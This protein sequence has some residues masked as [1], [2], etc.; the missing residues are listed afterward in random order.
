MGRLGAWRRGRLVRKPSADRP[1]LPPPR[2]RPLTPAPDDAVGVQPRPQP[3]NCL[4]FSKLPSDLRL[5]ILNMAFGGRMLHI[6]L[7]FD[8]PLLPPPLDPPAPKDRHH[9]AIYT[10]TGKRTGEK[11]WQWRGAVCHRSDRFPDKWPV[12][13]AF[14]AFCWPWNDKCM[15]GEGAQRC[16]EAKVWPEQCQVGIMGYLLSCRQAWVLIS[17]V[18][19]PSTDGMPAT[20]RASIRSSPPATSRLLARCCSCI[21]PSSSCP[22]AWGS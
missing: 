6:D 8:Y 1:P 18:Q 3:P 5:E 17:H 14:F 16:W 9:A 19:R 15:Q 20:P 12:P 13:L 11:A 21:F 22:S 10:Q 2:P 4:L 7:V